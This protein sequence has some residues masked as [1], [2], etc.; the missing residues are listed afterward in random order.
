MSTKSVKKL[1]GQVIRYTY[2][3][4]TLALN[5]GEAGEQGI[6]GQISYVNDC[7]VAV[8]ND[9]I[10][11]AKVS[12]INY[13]STYSNTVI[14]DVDNNIII[15]LPYVFY[16][17]YMLAYNGE[18]HLLGGTNSKKTHYI[19]N[20][21]SKTGR[22]A[23]SNLPQDY[24]FAVAVVAGDNKIHLFGGT[25]NKRHYTYDGTSWTLVSGDTPTG[26]NRYSSVCVDSSG[27]I[28][29]FSYLK[30]Y[31]YDNSSWT[32][33]SDMPFTSNNMLTLFRGNEIHGFS[34][35]VHYVYNGTNLQE[36]ELPFY[37][38]YAASTIVNNKFVLIGGS[39][40]KGLV[41]YL[42]D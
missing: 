17:G 14:C 35:N 4:K 28:H 38:S 34:Y 24:E 10:Y 3:V 8:I 37:S 30:H 32:T 18:I 15:T 22:Y 26:L 12:Y 21:T 39:M 11:Y 33:L 25:N 31:K 29:I 36:Y 13:S 41:Y 23:T 1:T 16:N 40:T 2:N 20:V 7:G 42:T 27:K 5:D 9:Q 6:Y 19:V